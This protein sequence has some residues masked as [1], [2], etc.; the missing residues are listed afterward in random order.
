MPNATVFASG[1]GTLAVAPAPNAR[2]IGARPTT[3]R[4][5]RDADKDHGDRDQLSLAQP[6]RPI[7]AV[8][9]RAEELDDETLN[10]SQHGPDAEQPSFGMLVIAHPPENREHHEAE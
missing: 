7:E 3:R 9:L 6:E 10:P 5:D 2:T 4:H 1:H 8:V